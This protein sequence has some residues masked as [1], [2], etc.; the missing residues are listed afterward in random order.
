[1][2]AKKLFLAVE[3]R[4]NEAHYSGIDH[5]CTLLFIDKRGLEK[6]L[7]FCSQEA[8]QKLRYYYEWMVRWG[9]ENLETLLGETCYLPMGA[10]L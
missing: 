8:S 1:M 5:V 9:S 7:R 3:R 6:C 4:D 10:K 2:E